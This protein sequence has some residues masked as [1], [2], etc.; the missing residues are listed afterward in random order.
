MIRGGHRTRSGTL[1][2]IAMPG[3]RPTLGATCGAGAG[4]AV[5]VAGVVN[6]RTIASGTIATRCWIARDEA[7]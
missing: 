6:R 3:I 5:Y 2:A 4:F 7:R 1:P